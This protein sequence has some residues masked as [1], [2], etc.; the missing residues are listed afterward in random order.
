MVTKLTGIIH[1]S[2][3]A[4]TLSRALL[5]KQGTLPVTHVLDTYFGLKK[6]S[7]SLL[8]TYT[9]IQGLDGCTS[10]EIRNYLEIL[11]EK[12]KM[13]R[14]ELDSMRLD[15]H[16]W[17]GAGSEIKLLHRCLERDEIGGAMIQV[18]Y[19]ALLLAATANRFAGHKECPYKAGI[20]ESLDQLV[21]SDIQLY[22]FFKKI[23]QTD[24]Y[25]ER[26]LEDFLNI[27]H[28]ML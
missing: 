24:Q 4:N 9:K 2:G 27:L 1:W 6:T 17:H 20:S 18:R 16:P 12:R 10:E 7:H 28:G 25:S 22:R 11:Q 8:S 5:M 13:Q 21:Q 15:S 14:K 19:T 23:H 26:T 3:A